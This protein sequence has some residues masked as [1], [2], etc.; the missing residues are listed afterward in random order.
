MIVKIISKVRL[1]DCSSDAHRVPYIGMIA[2]KSMR[3]TGRY[4]NIIV[5]VGDIKSCIQCETCLN[6]AQKRTCN[7]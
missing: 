5:L 2:K 1:D 6:K 4:A 7:E 3:R